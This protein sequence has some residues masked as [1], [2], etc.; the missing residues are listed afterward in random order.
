MLFRSSRTATHDRGQN[1]GRDYAAEFGI[2]GVTTDPALIG[3]PRFTVTGLAAIGDA[4]SLPADF[5]VNNI[6]SGDT[7]TWVKGKH[8]VKMGGDIL[9]IQLFE[10][11]LNN[12]RGTFNFLGRWTNQPYADFLLGLPESASRQVGSS[13]NYLF[14]T[15][16]GFFAQDDIKLASRF[17]LNLGIRYEI[18]KPPNEKYGRITNFIP[19]LG[20]LVLA[21]DSTLKGSGT[22][23]TDAGKVG[24][25][26]NL[27]LPDSLVY[28]RYGDIAPR[29]GFAWRP[30]GGNRA[31]VR[32][33]YGIFYGNEVIN[34][35]RNS[36]ANVFPFVISQTVTRKAN[37]S[38]YLTLANPFPVA[39]T[40]TS[41]VTNVNGFDLHAPTPYT[42]SWNLT[43][44]RE[45]GLGSALEI[46]YVGA[47]GTHL[48]REYDINQPIRSAALAPN[49]PRPYPL[50]GTMNYYA[51]GAN[52]IYNAGTL[53][54]RRR[55][56]GGFFFRMNY[57]YSKSIDDASQLSGSSAGGV[58]APQ[59]SRDL[60]AER[61]RSDWDR[62]HVFTM[63]FSYAIPVR[64]H[65]LLR[66][67]QLAGTGRLYSGPP[68][69][70]LTSNVNLA[71]GDA[72]RPDRV[73]KGPASDPGPDRWF[74][75]KAFPVVSNGSFRFGNSGRNILDAPGLQEFN[76][77]L[78][79]NF[80]LTERISAQFR[81][82]AFNAFNHANFGIPN[83]NVN[84]PAAATIAM[85]GT[86]RLMQF[87]LKLYF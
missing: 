23:F 85:A 76:L 8:L 49:F 37:D 73:A 22:S 13:P 29:V 87:G 26:R 78:F 83:R 21:D 11:Y 54:L 68:F 39:P 17:T 48:G 55:F 67:W 20:L 5:A 7:L 27:G 56:S 46:A 86:P 51:F 24:V 60:R 84:E 45:I 25:A 18:P 38:S 41:G 47:K 42:Q 15:N 79:K 3:L 77:T 69:T 12:N 40:L 16:Y 32:G 61:G 58:G 6:Q 43:A 2:R 34:P 10:P 72:S 65:A 4:N 82:E 71:L 57:T 63:N 33:G 59:N 52:S 9:R 70:P 19:E 62:G 14:S 1:Q 66:G 44:E 28:T 64:G 50:F 81:G 30:F 36:L 35:I 31:V 75:V 80:A 74:D 53:S